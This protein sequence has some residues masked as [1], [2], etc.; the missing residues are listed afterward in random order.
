M[1][2]NPSSLQANII[3]VV[4]FIGP[5]SFNTSFNRNRLLA[6]P[7]RQSPYA[8]IYFVGEPLNSTKELHYTGWILKPDYTHYE[9]RNK[10]GNIQLLQEKQMTVM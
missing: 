8:N 7:N 9:D 3:D 1:D 5:A 2:G 4:I 6:Y 10:D